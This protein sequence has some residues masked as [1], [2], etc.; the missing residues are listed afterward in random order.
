MDPAV[1]ENMRRIRASDIEVSENNASHT[2]S[3]D[4]NKNM[5]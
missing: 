3:T 5:D 1:P 4:V 2:Y